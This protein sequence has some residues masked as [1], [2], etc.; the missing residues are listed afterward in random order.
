MNKL[1][2]IKD[3]YQRHQENLNLT[4]R[5]TKII[6]AIEAKVRLKIKD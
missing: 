5:V 2:N 3:Q 4:K 1:R 6:I